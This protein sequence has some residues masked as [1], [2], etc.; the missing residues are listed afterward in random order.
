LERKRKM[1]K[2]TYFI[3]VALI[4]TVVASVRVIPVRAMS[5]CNDTCEH[6]SKNKRG[7]SKCLDSCKKE[8]AI[9]KAN[10]ERNMKNEK[11]AIITD[12]KFRKCAESCNGPLSTQNY[13]SCIQK[14]KKAPTGN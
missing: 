2:I 13:S 4:I 14:C 1:K 7:F 11:G 8:E 12:E 9:T 10:R 5:G 6:T 3:L